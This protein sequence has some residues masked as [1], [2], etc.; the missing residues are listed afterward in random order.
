MKNK[1]TKKGGSNKK[2]IYFLVGVICVLS[3]V[4]VGLYSN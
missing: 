2:N 3:A 1:E 4:V